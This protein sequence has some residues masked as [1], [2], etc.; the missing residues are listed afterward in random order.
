MDMTLSDFPVSLPKKEAP[1]IDLTEE[2]GYIELSD[3]EQDTIVLDADID[4]PDIVILE[5]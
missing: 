2:G 5:G 1:V 3:D 4:D